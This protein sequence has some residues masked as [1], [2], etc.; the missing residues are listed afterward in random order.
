M[1]EA[2]A[3]ARLAN[4]PPITSTPCC[5]IID[6]KPCLAP[7]SIASFV[8]SFTTVK[9]SFLPT[10]FVTHA[11]TPFVTGANK[12]LIEP[13]PASYNKSLPVY[14]LPPVIASPALT[15]I[16][17]PA[18]AAAARP[19]PAIKEVPPVGTARANA[20]TATIP[21]TISP[22]TSTQVSCPC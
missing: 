14:S 19:S 13:V 11:P 8:P 18:P 3:S 4:V 9:P 16:L 12:P 21:D 1:P 2:V 17:E 15:A 20:P 6:F 7:C 10:V 22:T 5:V